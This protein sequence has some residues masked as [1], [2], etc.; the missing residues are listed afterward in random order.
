MSDKVTDSG[1]VVVSADGKS[2]TVTISGTEFTYEP[3]S[4][5][6]TVMSRGMRNPLTKRKRGS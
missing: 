5:L 4:T 1:R 2:R 3:D 6:V